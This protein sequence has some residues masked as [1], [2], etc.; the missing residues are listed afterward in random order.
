MK[1]EGNHWGNLWDKPHQFLTSLKM[2]MNPVTSQWVSYLQVYW[3]S[4]FSLLCLFHTLEVWNKTV[5]PC[6]FWF[7]TPKHGMGGYLYLFVTEA[8]L[9]SFVHCVSLSPI[10][11]GAVCLKALRLA[12]YV[13]K[14]KNFVLCSE[15]TLFVFPTFTTFFAVPNILL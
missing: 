14:T 8:I 6:T 15:S 1:K 5:L 13:K 3:T 7:E 12:V 2:S 11:W 10:F 4:P 9:I